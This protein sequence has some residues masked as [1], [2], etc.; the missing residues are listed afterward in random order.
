MDLGATGSYLLSRLTIVVV[1]IAFLALGIYF[2]ISVSEGDFM[3]PYLFF[4]IFFGMA[5]VLWLGNK[6]WLLI[7]L[8][9]SLGLPAIP[10]GGRSIEVSEM[11]TLSVFGVFLMRL[12]FSKEKL[13]LISWENLPLYGYV[14]CVLLVYWQNPA[15][16][17]AFGSAA[18]GGRFY[19]KIGLALMSY[20]IISGQRITSKDAWWIALSYVL[21]S[22]IGVAWSIF[23]YIVF[24]SSGIEMIATNQ[25]DS[26]ESLYTWHQLMSDGAAPVILWIVCRYRIREIFTFERPYLPVIMMAAVIFSFFSGKRSGTFMVLFFPMLAA[27][28]R[29]EFLFIFC[30]GVLGLMGIGTMVLGQGTLFQLPFQVQRV[31]MNLPGDWDVRLKQQSGSSLDEFRTE[32]NRRAMEKIEKAPWMGKGYDI[33]MQKFQS[34]TG[35]ESQYTGFDM[36]VE[37]LAQGSAWHNTW[38]GISADFGIPAAVF[39]ALFF[40]AALYVGYSC[41]WYFE[42]GNPVRTLA[43]MLTFTLTGLVLFSWAGGHSAQSPYSQWWMYGVLV[44]IYRTARQEKREKKAGDGGQRTAEMMNAEVRMQNSET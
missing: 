29:R 41:I 33:N 32:M 39:Y 19:F 27:L 16:L 9:F 30:A 44:A 42:Q 8:G 11:V 36:Y 21:G 3:I 23:S 31:L 2:A 12:A 35:A 24:G 40:I 20:L 15:G 4:I 34:I 1:T 5:G 22:L 10:L 6:V 38:L 25:P 14:T 26:E 37:L 18:G 7:P 28:L 13:N 17:L 43:M